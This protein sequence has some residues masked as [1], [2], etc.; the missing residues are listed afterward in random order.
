MKN[1]LQAVCKLFR[2]IFLFA[3]FASSL[4]AQTSFKVLVVASPDPDHGEMIIPSKALLEKIGSENGFE[5]TFTRDASVINDENLANYKVVVQLHLAPFEMNQQEQRAM[6]DFISRG[7][8]WVGIHAAGLTGKQFISPDAPYWDWYQKLLGDV[9]YSPH[10]AKQTGTIIVEDREHPVMK[11]LPASFSFYDEWY[12]FNKSP[13]ANVHVLATA[14]ESSYKPL[15]PMG[16]HP[17]I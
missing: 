2:I 11:N 13:R 14:D 6:Q 10:P 4:E 17:I 1:I 3:I 7:K 12:E 8:G 5:I 16:D 9:I 15:K